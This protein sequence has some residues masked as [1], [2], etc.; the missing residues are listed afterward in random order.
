MT[1]SHNARTHRVVKIAAATTVLAALTAAGPVSAN[2]AQ[3]PSHGASGSAADGYIY[4]AGRY[5]ALTPLHGLPTGQYGINDRGTISGAYTDAQVFHGFVRDPRGRY[6]TFEAAPSAAATAPFHIND[7]GAIAGGYATT[8]GA[9]GFVR[10]PDGKVTTVD[11]PGA[12]ATILYGVNDQ[13]AVVGQYVDTDSLEHGFELARGK[14]TVIDPPGAP[15]DPADP[16]DRDLTAFDINDRGQVVGYYADAHGTYHGY[17]YDHGRFTKLDPPRAADVPGFATAA[18]IGINDQGEVV[19]QYVDKARV[20]HGFLWRRGRGFTTVNPPKIT[21][22]DN[23]GVQ[24]AGTIATD[25]NDRGQILLPASG[26]LFKGRVAPI[27]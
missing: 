12:V 20:L 4:R 9:H 18:A 17:L 16:T 5:T 24:G 23:N 8:T 11:V 3:R 14:L 19:G 10:H 15:A 22:F 7:Q 6:T 1:P 21:R 25:I 27:G 2:A 26:I 13:G